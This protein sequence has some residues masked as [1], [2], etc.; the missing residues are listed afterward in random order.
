MNEGASACAGGIEG[1]CD[2]LYFPGF[3]WPGVVA[4]ALTLLILAFLSRK[5]LIKLQ[6]KMLFAGWIVIALVF[7]GIVYLETES[8]GERTQQARER[9]QASSDPACEY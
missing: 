9:C 7:A 4:L 2:T 8:A 5:K 1:A 6:F 3:L